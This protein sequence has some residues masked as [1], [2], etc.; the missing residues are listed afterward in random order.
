MPTF[1]ASSRPLR[2]ALC[3]TG[4]EYGGAE[5][6]LA[7]LAA[8]IDRR[9][10]EPVVYSLASK[11]TPGLPSVVPRLEQAGVETHFLHVQRTAQFPLAVRRLAALFR[12]Q[13]PDLVQ[14][15]LF[16]ANIVGRWAAR[17]AEVTPVL[18]GIRVAERRGRWRL[19]L[20]RATAGN[21]ARHVCVSQAVADFAANIGGLP[22]DRLVVIPNGIEIEAYRSAVPSDL[23]SLGVPA[24]RK[25]VTYIGRLDAQKRVDWLLE[26][27]ADWLL[28][29]P[30]HDLLIV[31]D[32]PK[33]RS[34][35]Q[36]AARLG[37]GGRVHF[38]G[39]R[40]EVPAILAASELLVLPSAWEGMPN[41]VL[42]AMAAGLPVVATAA[43]GVQELLGP[44]AEGQVVEI[45]DHRGF[46]D[47]VQSIVSNKLL[48]NGLGKSNQARAE[49]CFSL[50]SMVRAYENLWESVSS[51]PS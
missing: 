19:W 15:F 21:V 7:E 46:C 22:R 36:S 49:E 29:A 24:G 47:A 48:G 11:P 40:A 20:D 6:C 4:L 25:L 17:R 38:A 51:S 44:A 27:S 1:D 5:K 8:R 43:E 45:D 9:R 13:R 32:G 26:L 10:F 14:T 31:G 39:W 2:I 50:S 33:R 18:A 23:E 41:V 42:E 12:G 16:H 28:A 37:I 3:I 34:L 30:Q 35:E